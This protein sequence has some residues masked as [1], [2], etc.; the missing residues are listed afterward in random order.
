MRT[1]LNGVTSEEEHSLPAMVK[2]YLKNEVSKEVLT[3]QCRKSPITVKVIRKKQQVQCEWC[4]TTFKNE[5][6]TSVCMAI[7]GV[8]CLSTV[9]E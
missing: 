4:I 7:T 9:F 2:T 1:L 5:K 3:V 8:C 6:C